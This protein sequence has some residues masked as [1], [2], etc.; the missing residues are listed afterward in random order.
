MKKKYWQQSA[1]MSKW[2]VG[3]TF[4]ILDE[5][6]ETWVVQIITFK[7]LINKPEWHEFYVLSLLKILKSLQDILN[8]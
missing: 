8:K 2:F 1:K 3:R 5:V 7:L 4:H 6:Q